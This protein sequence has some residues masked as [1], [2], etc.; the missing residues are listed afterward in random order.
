MQSTNARR[1][2]DEGSVSV[3][4]QCAK[5]LEF[6]ASKALSGASPAAV[7]RE[8]SSDAE[9]D[10]TS[11]IVQQS[12]VF[13]PGVTK[14]ECP[15]PFGSGMSDRVGIPRESERDHHVNGNYE[16]KQACSAMDNCNGGPEIKRETGF[17]PIME[18]QHEGEYWRSS[19]KCSDR[20][21]PPQTCSRPD[22]YGSSQNNA[23]SSHKVTTPSS[24]N[25]ETCSASQ[26]PYD[27]SSAILRQ[28]TP[29]RVP[30]STTVARIRCGNQGSS[31]LIQ[32]HTTPADVQVP[33]GLE[34]PGR[35]ILPPRDVSQCL[36]SAS[37][38]LQRSKTSADPRRLLFRLQ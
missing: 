17:D 4:D 38:W 20:T 24:Q 31:T 32:S 2:P 35:H 21:A 3:A 18:Q 22:G 25:L 10:I 28:L 36:P 6:S 8:A 27:M 29:E 5:S 16:H 12:I 14:L 30:N 13:T 19:G 11:S 15:H 1:T 33:E 23:A 7:K 9:G 34:Q 37:Q 26:K